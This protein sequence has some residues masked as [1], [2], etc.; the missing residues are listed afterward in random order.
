M[1]RDKCF[2]ALAGESAAAPREE[3]PAMT[4]ALVV[5]CYNEQEALPL[6]YSVIARVAAELPPGFSD[7]VAT[8][9]LGGLEKSAAALAA[10]T[11]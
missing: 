5:P 3:G 10:M 11:E 4:L 7:H 8:T 1:T 6:F 9:L 2:H